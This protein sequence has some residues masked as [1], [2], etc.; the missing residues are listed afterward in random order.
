MK[1][2]KNIFNLGGSMYPYDIPVGT[3]MPATQYDLLLNNQNID[4][5]KAKGKDK[6]TNPFIGTPK[7]MFDLGGDIQ[8]NG[9]DFST[10]AIHI[11][12]GKSHEENPNDGVQMGVDNDGTPNLVE[13][14]EV[15]YN[16]YVFSNRIMLDEE[17]K[18]KLH[19]PKKKDI[20]YADAAKRLEKEIAE[21]PNDPISEV[22]FKS[23]MQTLEEAQENQKAQMEAARAREAFE[24][25]SPEEQTAIMQQAAQQEQMAQQ[26]SQEQAMAEQQ[27]AMQQPSPEEMAMAQQAQMQADGSQA[28]LGQEAPMM[29]YGGK[30]YKYAD[31]GLKKKIYSL[32]GR[33]TDKDFRSWLDEMGDKDLDQEAIMDALNKD[34]YEALINNP[35]FVRALQKENRG[36]AHSVS[37]GNNFGMYTPDGSGATFT[38][39]DNGNWDRQMFEG[40][41]GSKDAAWEELVKKYGIEH[42][43]GIEKR[44]DLER[45][46]K[47]TNAYKNTTKWLQSN[48]ENMRKY[49]KSV[50]DTSSSD[51]AK[52]H[53]LQFVNEDGTWKDANKIPTYAQIFGENGKGVRET[54]PGT[55][56]HSVVEANRGKE[57]KNYLINDDGSIDL[58]EG[59]TD[60]LTAAG[61][62]SWQSPESDM[63][64]NY[65]TR[66]AAPKQAEAK[67]PAQ[68]AAEDAEIKVVPDL[69]KE[70]SWGMFGPAIGLGLMA[71][72]LGKPDT[73]AYDAAIKGVGNVRYA[74]YQP[75]GNYLTYK[76]LDIW[77]Q[78]NALNA[79]SR[80]TDRALLNST[81]PSRM[82]GLLS[83]GYN[84]QL[85]SGNL[86]RQ[87]QEY[88][89]A[90]KQK[91]E[92]F[93]RGTNQFN[94]E[95]YNRNSQFNADAFN[96]ANRASAQM[97]LHA[98]QAKDDANRW[99]ASN[100]YGNINGLFDNINQWEKWKRDHN[101]I[102]KMYA[103]GLAGTITEDNPMGIGMV[104]T[105]TAKGGKLKK[106]KRGL[107]I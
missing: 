1:A 5:M 85:A 74:D 100:L 89:D 72:G 104:K 48:P 69:K 103:N 56:W 88:N 29:A 71:T 53:A 20:T 7:T 14:G 84:S 10:G 57:Q 80:A 4:V 46:F 15:V 17:A 27:A 35:A 36:L 47:E 39:P 32:L 18:K 43:K 65:F 37:L 41:N 70:T 24:A 9:A 91:V 75:I 8:M 51:S 19:F 93:N 67:T 73:G 76:P 64:V 61:T 77:Y 79:Q 2:R 94:A 86:F 42:L 102:A 95:A 97:Q 3:D 6:M 99:W 58:I 30:V 11:N 101:T 82:A 66:P 13:E 38:D 12:A 90:L 31:G 105:V 26:A 83:N 33:A 87:A 92:E 45:I 81:S 25:L 23:Q 22:G 21:R 98:A 55:Y 52:K 63:T 44:E 28:A 16:D 78:Q 107:T 96:T 34:D 50:L 59:T 106:K 40:W 62:H 49:L 60:G 54:Y 68:K